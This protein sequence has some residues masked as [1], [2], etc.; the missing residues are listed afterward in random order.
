MTSGEI[1][2]LAFNLG[3]DVLQYVQQHYWAIP[4]SLSGAEALLFYESALGSYVSVF[5]LVVSLG[6]ADFLNTF[7]LDYRKLI[8]AISTS[9]SG[10][11]EWMQKLGCMVINPS[12]LVSLYML[13]EACSMAFTR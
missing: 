4:Y 1:Q 2:L 7:G 3:S 8:N 10:L 13:I 9:L 12:A 5:V 6:D 11:L